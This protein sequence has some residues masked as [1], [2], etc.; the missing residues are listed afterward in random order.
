MMLRGEARS[1]RET[2]WAEFR[3]MDRTR[4]AGMQQHV[5][6]LSPQQGVADTFEK[7]GFTLFFEIYSDLEKAVASF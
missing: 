7:A 4:D 1:D 3:S 5:K 2:G 6:L